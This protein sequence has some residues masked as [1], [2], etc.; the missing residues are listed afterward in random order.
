MSLRIHYTGLVVSDAQAIVARNRSDE[1]VEG[2]GIEI[3]R[4]GTTLTRNRADRNAEYGIYAVPGTIDGGGNRAKS[5]GLAD[6]LNV[7]CK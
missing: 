5:N 6:C 7:G 3:F 1:S 2:S 4:P